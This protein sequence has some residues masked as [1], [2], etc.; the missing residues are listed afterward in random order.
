VSTISENW[1][2]TLLSRLEARSIELK[3]FDDYYN[4]DHPMPF[5]TKAHEAKMRNEFVNMLKDSQ[6][7]FMR[8]VVD[9]VEE[10]LKVEGFR[11]SATSDQET[12][13]ATWD[14]WQANQLDSQSQVAFVESLIKGV[15]YMS[16]W[17]S[18]EDG[19]PP[20]I[21]VEDPTETI[22]AYEPGSNYQRRLAALKVWRDEDAGLRRA[23]VYLPDGIWKYKSDLG[24]KPAAGFGQSFMR[25]FLPTR[26]PG[27]DWDEIPGSWVP[28]PIGVVPIVPLRNRPR[29]L[30][31]GES[32]LADVFHVQNQINGMLFLLQLAGYMGA[33]RQ[34]WVSGLK[35]MEDT[36][37]N[38]V[39]PFN[40]A[41][42]KLW[43]AENPEV[44]FGEF[45]QTML[46]GYL[47]SIDQKVQHIAVTTRTPKHYLIPTGQEPSGD[48]IKSAESG[49]VKKILRKQT[50]FGE[51]LEETL[52]LARLFAGES[53]SPVDSEVVWA[54]PEITTEA[55][56]VDAAAKKLSLGLIDK[57]QALEDMGY[58]QQQITRMLAASPEAVTINPDPNADPTAP[59]EPVTPEEEQA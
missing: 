37:G 57:A 39:E 22:V 25:S 19:E 8:L 55:E 29:L 32:E 23:N 24:N 59:P 2:R 30:S 48:A 54:S 26:Q 35:I 16:V 43:Q 36:A 34:R 15:S 1:L 21:C 56:Q 14:I 38:P 52:R 58:T 10:R 12:D 53:D 4:G 6:A 9:V 45:E 7:N 13:K 31:E 51:G 17:S 33:H 42:D 18:D 20:V 46:D 3:K 50:V 5:L 49:L 28:N 44:K 11:L 41:V 27:A 40:P 47:K